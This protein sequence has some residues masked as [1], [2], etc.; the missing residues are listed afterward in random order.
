MGTVADYAP[1]TAPMVPSIIVHCV[2]EV[3]L[4][5]LNEVGIYRVPGAE[6]DVK[7]LKVYS[8]YK[9]CLVENKCN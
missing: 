4:R 1:H 5:G 3:E 7:G 9:S 8:T 2:N 6:K